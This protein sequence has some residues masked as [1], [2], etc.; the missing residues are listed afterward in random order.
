M[1]RSDWGIV[2]TI[3]G[4]LG[5]AALGLADVKGQPKSTIYC[6]KGTNGAN[7]RPQQYLTERSGIPGF[8]ERSISNPEPK[9]GADHEKRDLAAQEA[10]AVFAFWMLVVAA[11]SA[12]ITLIGTIFLFQ[13]IVLTRKAVEDTGRA[14]DAMREANKIAKDNSHRELRAYLAARSLRIEE[15]NGDDDRFS[16]FISI[17]N[18]GQTP[19]IVQKIVFKAFWSFDGGSTTLVEYE[20]KAIFKCHRDTP[21]QFPFSF[22]GTFENC[23]KSGHV[24]VLGRIDYRDAFGKMQKDSFGWQTPSEE[25]GPFYDLDLPVQL[26]SYSLETALGLI[27]RQQEKNESDR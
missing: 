9:T 16:F 11:C 1:L 6:D 13:Q 26:H 4:C 23:D 27:K 12:V 24:F 25:Y 2:F 7:C 17:A 18:H 19:G 8:F 15:S 3:V 21:V 22:N 10:S 14:T 5:L 20:E